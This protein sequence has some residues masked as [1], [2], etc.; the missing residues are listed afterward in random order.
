MFLSKKY[1]FNR[2]KSL[3]E[4]V[5]K[6]FLAIQDLLDKRDWQTACINI[7]QLGVYVLSSSQLQDSTSDWEQTLKA[8]PPSLNEKYAKKFEQL[9]KKLE[10]VSFS[11]QTLPPPTAL[12]QAEELFKQA[13]NLINQFSLSFV[14]IYIVIWFKAPFPA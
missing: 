11:S 13:K 9:F 3:K 12:K 14:I 8:L 10:S 6:K 2:E 5:N 1:I 7:I 4:K